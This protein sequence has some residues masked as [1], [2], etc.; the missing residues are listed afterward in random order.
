MGIFT[1]QKK[2]IKQKLKM[3]ILMMMKMWI[4]PKKIVIQARAGIAE[5]EVSLVETFSNNK[6]KGTMMIIMEKKVKNIT[7]VS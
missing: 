7:V 4:N 1:K 5:M 3:I 2:K 6:L